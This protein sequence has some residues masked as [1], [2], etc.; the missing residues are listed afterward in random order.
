MENIKTKITHQEYLQLQ[1][2]FHLGCEA[3][4][5]WQEYERAIELLM[6]LEENSG[7]LFGDAIISLDKTVDEILKI[8]EVEVESNPTVNK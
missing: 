3:S 2:L 1:G 5:K 8:Y 4:K 6:N 7:S